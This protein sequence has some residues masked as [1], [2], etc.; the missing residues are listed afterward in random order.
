MHAFH[1]IMRGLKTVYSASNFKPNCLTLLLFFQLS[2][3]NRPWWT[4]MIM[5][6]K[7]NWV[8]LC[9][10]FCFTYIINISWSALES[11]YL[12][13]ANVTW[14]AQ[15]W[16]KNELHWQPMQLMTSVTNQFHRFKTIMPPNNELCL[17]WDIFC[18]ARS[19]DLWLYTEEIHFFYQPPNSKSVSI[20]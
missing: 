13:H 19:I 1:R 15:K 7:Q 3:F 11:L 2:A 16:E 6:M 18:H 10:Q 20:S 5:I 8:H 14:W 17:D 9:T 12:S 4:S